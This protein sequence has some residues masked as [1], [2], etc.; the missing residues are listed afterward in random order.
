MKH[1]YSESEMVEYIN[2]YSFVCTLSHQEEKSAKVSAVEMKILLRFL[3]RFLR[4]N[5]ASIIIITP[6]PLLFLSFC[7]TINV[8]LLLH[9]GDAQQFCPLLLAT[10]VSLLP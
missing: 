6:R 5:H 4:L 10:G 3:I 9:L 7:L 2:V 1:I 8:A